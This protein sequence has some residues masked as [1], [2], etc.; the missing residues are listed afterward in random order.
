MPWELK[1]RGGKVLVC[2]KGEDKPVPGGVHANAAEAKKHLAALYASEKGSMGARVRVS[3]IES[4]AEF[5]QRHGKDGKFV[6][7][8]SSGSKRGMSESDRATAKKGVDDM[9]A[10]ES[11]LGSHMDG[12]SGWGRVSRMGSST[13]SKG[14]VHRKVVGDKTA[15]IVATRN[16]GEG[17]A[18]RYYARVRSPGGIVDAMHKTPAEA[19]SWAE[20]HLKGGS[21]KKRKG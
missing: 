2:K 21:S 13:P 3:V 17:N 7:T 16:L 18:V 5:A 19:H 11:A 9:K 8:G 1:K 10:G 20:G 15:E 12:K 6:G 14:N 4:R